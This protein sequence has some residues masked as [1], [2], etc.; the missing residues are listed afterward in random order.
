MRVAIIGLGPKGLFA[1]ERLLHHARAIDPRAAIAIDAF[2]PHPTPGAGPVYALDQAA[3]L[4]MNFRADQVDMWP[5]GSRAV[6]AAA[7]L[8]FAG[9]RGP[10]GEVYPPRADVG[11]YL[12]DGLERLRE[13]APANVAIR[14]RPVRVA[15]VERED[16]R[17]AVDGSA[18]DEVLVATGHDQVFRPDIR[19]DGARIRPGARVV[20]R[21]F[22]L[23]FIDAALA[24]TE[25]RGGS[26]EPDGH[27][28]RYV[29]GED[30]IGV[31]LPFSRTG[32]PMLAKPALPPEADLEPVAAVG[33][34]AILALPDGFDVVA[35]LEAIVTEVAS[36][37]LS[38]GAPPLTAPVG[39]A[40]ALQRSLAIAMDAAPRDH[41]WALGHAWRALYPAI[42]ERIGGA[43]LPAQQ[44]P[45]FH[46]LARKMERIAFGPPP[47]NAAKL[48]ALI[49]AGRVDLSA[50]LSGG[51]NLHADATINTVIPGPGVT[52]TAQPLL[53]S[54]IRYGHARTLPQATRTRGSRR[55][56]LRGPR[57]H[58][59]ARPG[60]DR[61]PDR[62]L[63]RRQR[64]TEPDA[65]PARGPVGAARA[66]RR[67]RP[68]AGG[69]SV[70]DGCVG[71]APLSARLEPWQVELLGRPQAVGEWI[72]A[73]GSPINLLAPEP[74]R[75]NAG[76]LQQTARA[77]GVD[78]DIFFARK[79][80]KALAFVDEAVRL[81]LGV[82]LASETELRQ[83]LLRGVAPERLMM[84]AAVKPGSLLALCLDS[85]ATVAV[86]N[87]DELDALAALS[88]STGR[89]CPVALRLAPDLGPGRTPT[90]FGFDRDAALDAVDRVW[91]CALRIV[92]V[93]FHLDGYAAADR[94]AAITQSIELVD[95]LRERGHEIGFVDIGG[96]IPMSYLDD[97]AEWRTFWEADEPP[98]FEGHELGKVYPYHQEPVRG[99][100]LEQVL[101]PAVA[102][103]LRT[104]ELQLRCEPGRSLLDGCG[105]TVARVEFRKRRRDGTWLIG[106]AMNRTQCRS[107]SDDFMVDPLL[108]GAGEGDAIEGYL[109][110]AYCIERELITWRRLRFPSGVAVGDLVAFPN[111]AGYLMHILESSSH[112]IPLARN[113][114]V[115]GGR[116][117]LDDIDVRVTGDGVTGHGSRVTVT[118]SLLRCR[119]L[120]R[121]TRGR[122]AEPRDPSPVTR[123][124]AAPIL[125]SRAE[126]SLVRRAAAARPSRSHPRGG[127]RVAAR[128]APARD[129]RVGRR[130]RLR[131]HA[132]ARRRRGRARVAECVLRTVRRQDRL[133]PGARGRG[134]RRPARA[135]RRPRRGRRSGRRARPRHRDLPGL[136]AREPGY[137]ARL[138]GRAPARGRRR[139]PPA[140]APVRALRAAVRGA[141]RLDAQRRSEPAAAEPAGGA[142]AR[143]R[144]NGTRGDRG[145]DGAAR[146]TRPAARRRRRPDAAPTRLARRAVRSCGAACRR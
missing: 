21:G 24:L 71:V 48:L 23:T 52:G 11:R 135:P 72:E 57:R 103:A 108:V 124:P 62:G 86:D 4:R 10:G 41:A 14:I 36:L 140:R 61:S 117:T 18:Y 137:R 54:L 113:L 104:R 112:Q 7:Q 16:G 142:N 79:A 94:V 1:L 31:L 50:L 127:P 45:A 33:R 42:V 130:A 68:A 95:R 51:E 97:A 29:P 27:G 98:T 46:E 81:G 114:V 87:D 30:D 15:R 101:T 91:P 39:P 90:R 60:G 13:H 138:P 145:A 63:G 43:G 129:A 89:G 93:H 74:M 118:V 146:R 134:D 111:T 141:R 80:N 53:R 44:W 8:S 96:G 132:R 143:R 64:H 107:T 69:M 19:L 105:M 78:L 125:A 144:D 2:E 3:Y 73:H 115:A 34:A 109:V 100:W 77:R 76:E 58:G 136:V 128:P 75:R 55:R 85:G 20:A 120:L 110:G 66:G 56:E 12:A 9:W 25:G 47:E 121:D 92:G 131:R 59:H 32:L 139:R 35:E 40:E 88:A 82:D 65:A 26:F 116:A 84:T 67:K 102:D 83:V 106:L 126:R 6:P 119:A 99:E 38:G 123:H 22:A 5:V 28:L 17:W 70:R 133:L 37:S 49:D 122:A